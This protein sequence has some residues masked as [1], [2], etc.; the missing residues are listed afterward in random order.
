MLLRRATPADLPTIGEITV[1]A[2]ADFTLGPEDPYVAR[3]RDAAARHAEA[4]LWVAEDDRT[5]LGSVTWCPAGSVWREISEPDEGEFRMLSVA[6]EAR[7]RGVGEA[8]ARHC[9]DL[10]RAAGD[11]AMVLSSLAEMAN[12]HRLYARL[13]F[14]RL[15]E[16]DWSPMP[17]VELIAFGLRFT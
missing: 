1:T 13:G 14:T 4:E 11:R 5:L 8:L 12:A 6:P 10:S 9:V 3:L 17:G 2:Y 15:P 16:R 7:G